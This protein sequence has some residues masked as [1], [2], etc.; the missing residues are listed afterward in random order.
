MEESIRRRSRFGLLRAT[1]GQHFGHGLLAIKEADSE[2]E[3]F[4][5][6]DFAV[7]AVSAAEGFKWNGDA[8]QVT[9]LRDVVALNDFKEGTGQREIFHF[10]N[11][12]THATEDLKIRTFLGHI[13][14]CEYIACHHIGRSL[15]LSLHLP[16][17]GDNI[18]ETKFFD[19][20][21]RIFS[22]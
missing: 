12:C 17:I 13:A 19:G 22:F 2:A 9:L 1:A 11:E 3:A 14:F 5:P 10:S 16:I 15:C 18:L 6:D 20:Q 7:H 8:N 21:A 4:S